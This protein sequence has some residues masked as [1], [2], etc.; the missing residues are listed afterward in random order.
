MMYISYIDV[1]N[2]ISISCFLQRHAQKRWHSSRYYRRSLWYVD[3]VLL[4]AYV[5]NILYIACQQHIL[6]SMWLYMTTL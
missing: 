3:R 2:Y 1:S 4:I 6:Y 5:S